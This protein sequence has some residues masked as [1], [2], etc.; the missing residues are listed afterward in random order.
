MAHA[1]RRFAL[2]GAA[3]LLSAAYLAGCGAPT[4]ANAIPIAVVIGGTGREHTGIERALVAHP[5]SGASVR[6]VEPAATAKL[7][8]E[9]PAEASRLGEVRK[10]YLA[11]DVQGC[12][13]LV[14]T[15]ERIEALLASR[16]RT[17]AARAL[18]WR[19][20]CHVAGEQAA[21]AERDA[22]TF[23]ALRLRV[24]P[25]ARDA[26]P[27]VENTLDHALQRA[28]NE[29]EAELEVSVDAPRATVRLDGRDETCI[30]PCVM[31]APRGMHVV[32]ASADGKLAA[33]RHVSL[34]EARQ[35]LSIALPSAPPDVAAAQWR[36]RYQATAN[37]QSAE[38]ARL[39]GLAVP[40][41]YLV[42]LS[43]EREGSEARL[44]GILYYDKE[45]RA[46]AERVGADSPSSEVASHV[47]DE[48]LHRSKLVES[49][50]LV[51]SP[52]FWVAV[53]GT[54]AAASVV[55][56]LVLSTPEERTEVRLR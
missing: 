40:A 44:R 53:V 45:I 14:G 30:A 47:V 13:D 46:R 21:L 42:L 48:L 1:R 29:P 16:D 26:S 28:A 15:D 36:G 54:A 31:R 33:T 34:T 39:L 2:E 3:I 25:D 20:A 19:V 8:T 55:S 18:F 35:R 12:L 32:S 10:K 56:Y 9:L 43:P 37:E 41:R 50:P 24:P 11:A 38:S 7:E 6:V 52:L 51:S 23:A 4:R 27:D 22:A 17:G 49:K 5:V